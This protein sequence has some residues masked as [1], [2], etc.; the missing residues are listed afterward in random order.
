M[1]LRVL[2]IPEDARQARRLRAILPRR[3]LRISELQAGE[4]PLERLE[5]E[6]FDLFLAADALL[7]DPAERW[8]ERLRAAPEHPEL[9]VIAEREEPERRAR[10][11]AAGALSILFRGLSDAVLRETLRTLVQRRRSD[12]LLQQ[13]TPSA[14]SWRGLSSLSSLSEAMQRCLE[15]ARRLSDV[16]S[17]VLVLGETGVGKEHLVR[18]IHL[19]GRRR[20]GPFLAVNCAA[21]PE[22]LLES[23]LFGHEEGA[24]TGAVRARRGLFELAD[25]GTLLLDELGDLPVHLQAKLLRVLQDRVIRPVG[26][27]ESIPVDVRVIAATHR[28]LT[29]EVDA[30][31]FRADLYYRL[32]VVTL[33][34]P[35]LRERSEDIPALVA[36]LLEELAGRLRRPRLEVGEEAMAALL[37]HSWP[38]NVRE[39]ANVLERAVLLANGPRLELSD[40]P[41]AVRGRSR[42]PAPR[43]LTPPHRPP[44]EGDDEVFDLPWAEA[45]RRRIEPFE[46]AYFQRLMRT[47]GGRVGLAAHRAGLD[48]RTLYDKLR[49]LR[50]RK[51]DFRA[52]V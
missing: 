9:V 1:L 27:E 4:D 46:R 42:R 3:G 41:E 25:R 34:V 28:D 7:P 19:E 29:A 14:A 51:E 6:P 31:R 37:A 24:F 32:A 8:I 35:A 39:L 48:P 22:A 26:G 13:G 12:R 23:E 44:D 33:A 10:W 20:E 21:I 30:E 18:A 49:A 36:E 17:P 16:D 38:G 40:L 47:S 52:G 2:L 50:L 45:R 15:M 5:R 43:A 11:L